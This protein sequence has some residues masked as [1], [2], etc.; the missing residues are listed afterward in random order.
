MSFGDI[1]KSYDIYLCLCEG[2]RGLRWGIIIFAEV[3]PPL[4][5]LMEFFIYLSVPNEKLSPQEFSKK[6]KE[7]YPDYKDVDDVDL[8]KK[9]VEKYPDYADQVSFD[10]VKKK[11]PT[12]SPLQS[13]SVAGTSPLTATPSA[14]QEQTPEFQQANFIGQ[15]QK[16][17]EATPPQNTPMMSAA[18]TPASGDVATGLKTDPLNTTLGADLANS[19][20]RGSESLISNVSKAPAFVYNS[21]N[22]LINKARGL[23]SSVGSVPLEN[24][25]SK[26]LD[27]DVE[28]S[29]RQFES[30]YDKDITEYFSKGDY[31]KGF[32]KMANAI[33]ESAP[34]T[35]SLALGN[36]AGLGATSS[37]ILGGAVF[38]AGKKSELD[39]EVPDMPEDK[40]AA[41]AWANGLAEGFFEQFGLTKLGGVT[42]KI[43][44]ESGEEAAKKFA[45]EGFKKTYGKVLKQYLGTAAEESLGE[46][47]TQ[48]AQNAID[49]YSGY[50]PD[51]DLKKGLGDAFLVG[52]AS[53]G[54][55]GAPTSAM[56]F[57]KTRSAAKAAADIQAKKQAIETDLASENVSPEVKA[58]LHEKLKDLNVQDAELAAQ[59]KEKH[60][61]LQE[62]R[63]K[64]VENLH[65]KANELSSVVLDPNT[66]E[67]TK[68]AIKGDLDA[69]EGEIEKIYKEKS[70]EDVTE[71]ELPDADI[72]KSFLESLKKPQNTEQ[73]SGSEVTIPAKNENIIEARHSNTIEDDKGLTS[74]TGNQPLTEEG[75]EKAKELGEDAKN[76]GVETVI[77][78]DAKRSEQT[79]KEV[80]KIAGADVQINKK[81]SPWDI[82]EFDGMDSKEFDKLEKHFVEHPDEKEFDGKKLGESFNEYKDRILPERAALEEQ[83][84]KKTLII[85]HSKNI[86]LWDAVEKH[87]GWNEE[88]KKEF[89]KS[90][91][92]TPAEII[93]PKTTSNVK[94]EKTGQANETEKIT[95][96]KAGVEKTP[97]SKEL[98]DEEEQLEAKKEDDA[99]AI[100][101][102]NDDIAIL[103]GFSDKDVASKKFKAI[104]DRAFK[105]KDEGKISKPTYTRYRNIASQVLGPK[106]NLD[107]EKA[108]FHVE[109]M[110]EEVKKKLLGEGYKNIILTA[111]GFGPK[112]V[113]DLIDVTARLVNHAIDAGY[114]TKEAIQRAIDHVK[115][116]N[117]Y[118]KLVEGGHL[119][120]Q[121]FSKQV[122]QSFESPEK[123]EP[124][125][126][127]KGEKRE[128]AIGS[129][130]VKNE[131]KL[132]EVAK[133][134]K[135]KGVEYDSVDQKKAK[136][137]ADN[138]IA[139]YEKDNLLHDLVD[140][141]INGKS[142]IPYQVQGLVAAKLVDRLNVLAEG[143]DNE[144][145]KNATFD[146]AADLSMWWANEA[147]R[148]G[149]FN[150]VANQIIAQG[151]PTSKEGLR[152]F[153]QKE[154]ERL[155]DRL[156]TEDEKK[157]V[158]AVAEE[159]AGMIDENNLSKEHRAML[160]T[161][162]TKEIQRIT[163]KLK[164]KEFVDNL[165]A[166]MED[167]KMDLK[168]C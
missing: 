114:S 14:L 104:I 105:M 46:T 16:M 50:K 97:A 89:L 61:A 92:A 26:P 19:L 13:P 167:L 129:R 45:E 82:G 56:D 133:R 147:T 42:K 25:I 166:A 93:N 6:I 20:L 23:P 165:S 95:S 40:K 153:A 122:E 36:A 84:D 68:E 37:T 59:E 155:Q 149:Q 164:G 71:G 30:K 98:I 67:Q 139:E 62:E 158:A 28:E 100:K 103:K 108:K 49:K 4:L 157:Q 123:A 29:Q 127:I 161:M 33:A 58:T 57:A 152:Q 132:S 10:D 76:E 91:S 101:R 125:D 141:I 7:K 90:E 77:T 3:L 1:I 124:E 12:P 162:V 140:N 11:E 80:A 8:A 41:I 138:V 128:S 5:R 79:G 22:T 131:E 2:E 27:K 145:T 146:K 38:G 35:I 148:A 32:S 18:T 70:P 110:K 31:E 83:M 88:A 113:A 87:G 66:S 107:A 134:L 34:A 156:L 150:G 75:K 85:N 64:E 154:T 9:M 111:P 53:A 142:D 51:L 21:Y 116:T 163:E 151:L 121:E 136:D 118:K 115:G 109:Q 63:R 44:S 130:I 112:Q 102:L 47:A 48:F 120:E 15:D 65:R 96:E 159:I 43:L 60:E 99:E 135:K 119:N 39:K 168:D 72:E 126:K 54:T 137:Y 117:R 81:L 52:L 86:R 55:L 160:E 24:P 73:V 106:V 78:S 144:F 74:G 143:S 69:I 17:P 94:T